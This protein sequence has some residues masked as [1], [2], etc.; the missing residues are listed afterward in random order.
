MDAWA[1][2]RRGEATRAAARLARQATRSSPA[3]EGRRGS[4][5]RLLEAVGDAPAGEVVRRDLDPD[6][7]TGKDADAVAA[8]LAGQVAEHLVPVVELDAEHQAGQGLGDF[9]LEFDL[10]LYGH[11]HLRFLWAHPRQG[12][13]R[14]DVRRN[15]GTGSPVGRPGAADFGERVSPF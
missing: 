7:V 11:E 15:A 14:A 4:G 9:A 12:P 1:D 6:A 3:R 13:L 8:H 2:P 5:F 10:F